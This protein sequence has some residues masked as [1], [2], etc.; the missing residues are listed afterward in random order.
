MKEIV[1]LPGARLYR[2]QDG[3]HEL[4]VDT[5][6]DSEVALHAAAVIRMMATWPEPESWELR[7]RRAT[8]R[9]AAA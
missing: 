6:S 5:L 8:P 7:I 1:H 9:T 3:S 2:N 4:V